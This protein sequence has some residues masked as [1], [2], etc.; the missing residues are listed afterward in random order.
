MSAAD[1]KF[2]DINFDIKAIALSRI[3]SQYYGK[4]I[5]Q[6]LLLAYIEEVQELSTAISQLIEKRTINQAEG[7]QL[8]TIGK[9][10]GR[11]RTYYEYE[12][13]YWFAPD[14]A[15]VAPDSGHWWCY[16]A[17]QAASE[18]MDDVTYRKWLWMQILENHNLYS[19]VPEIENNIQDGIGETVGIQRTGMM[20]ADLYV[21]ENISLTNKKL[22]S[23]NEDNMLTDN[24]YLFPYPA[25]TKIDQVEINNDD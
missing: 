11:P 13:D 25:T 16:P 1:I 10:V 23:Y 24:D 20:E 8:D 4:K 3:L 14:N 9:I 17:P 2:N 21:T 7:L 5:M 22:L 6:M 18:K 19:S 12:E 15:G